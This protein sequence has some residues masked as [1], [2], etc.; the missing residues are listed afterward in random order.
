MAVEHH[1]VVLLPVDIDD[2]FF[3]GD[4]CQRLV[5]DLQ[6]FQ[7]FGGSV[8]LAEAAIYQ[9]Q[10][11]E[12][13]VLFPQ[14]L[15]SA[16]HHLAHGSKII[17][18]FHG[19]NN[20]FSVL[21]FIHLSVF[22]YHHGCHRLGPLDVGDVEALDS[23]GNLRQSECVLQSFLYGLGRR[24]HHP[25]TLV[26]RLLGVL[27]HQVDQRSFFSTLGHQ[28][29][30]FFLTLFPQ[31]LFQRSA[32]LKIHRHQNIVGN[33]L[34]I[35][36]DLLHQGREELSRRELLARPLFRQLLPEKLPAV[37]DFASAHVKEIHSQHLVFIVIGKNIDVIAFHGGHPLL[38]LKLLHGRDQVAILGC[39]LILLVL[40]GLVHATPQRP[41]KVC[42]AP[43]KKQLHVPHSL[44]VN[45]K[46]G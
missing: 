41:G 33:I 30:H 43:L 16:R 14:P 31:Q 17:H 21:G 40:G 11:G 27:C 36:I 6:P 24:F 15:I 37:Q 7:G 9:N 25:K 26:K 1:R 32:V 3:F 39:T 5:G 8:Q 46:I 34:L 19:T 22:P 38:F 35:N 12:T 29:L 18:A 2:L 23:L 45:L 10:A 13:F 28:N 4:G 20:E 44:L 42:L